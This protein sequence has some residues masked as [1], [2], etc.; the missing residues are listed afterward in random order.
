MNIYRLVCAST[1]E[2]NILVKARQKRHLD[3]LVM[4]EGSFS[5][6]SLFTS[7]GL[8]D[9]LGVASS[10][11]G[12]EPSSGA[13]DAVEVEAAMAAAE[14]ADDLS[15]MRGV[16]DEIALLES[17]FDESAPALEEDEE[18]NPR[19]KSVDAVDALSEE[20]ALELEFASWQASMGP[21]F[22]S[23]EKALKPVERFA[24]SFHTVIEPYYSMHFISEQNRLQEI[25]EEYSGA[26]WD[27]EEIE[28][29]KEEE[30]RRAMSEGELLASNVQPEEAAEL[31]E[32]YI[33]ER[34][35]RQRDRKNRVITGAG[36]SLVVD[37]LTKCPYWYNED[38]GDASYSRPAIVEELEN[39]STAQARRYN[40][41]PHA[42]LL[43]IFE[44]LAPYPDRVSAGAT[45]DRWKVAAKDSFF[46]KRVLSVESGAREMAAVGRLK[47]GEFVSLESALLSSLPG[48][49][50]VLGL[51]HHWEQDL[52][53]RS[54][55]RILSERDDDD[56]SKCVLELAGEVSFAPNI[57]VVFVGVTVRRPKKSSMRLNLFKAI[58][59]KLMV[60]LRCFP[61]L[62]DDAVAVLVRA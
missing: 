61:P 38:N 44:F 50:I 1:V 18:G 31:K 16:K 41:C 29:E 23:L 33:K 22:Q 21:D 13:L 39:Y 24:V 28:R 6:E 52:R 34:A 30:E 58:E 19:P 40:A 20:K 8:K 14:D 9:L 46:H 55:V 17:D 2:E 35:R 5:E 57:A 60:R 11:N 42:V 49:T 51:G 26:H 47:A 10:T 45:C 48:D 4:T 37:E 27:V 32:W 12:T 25:G 53:I 7:T 43:R 3:F 54:S 36:W 62:C 56:P 15:A 59:N